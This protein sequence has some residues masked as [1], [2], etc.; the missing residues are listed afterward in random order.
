MKR[1]SRLLAMTSAGALLALAAAPGTA[2]AVVAAGGWA[3]RGNGPGH[4]SRISSPDGLSPSTVAGLRRQ[5]S[6]PTTVWDGVAVSA[7][8]VYGTD[9]DGHLVA[10]SAADGQMLWTA[11]TCGGYRQND[12]FGGQTA[13]AVSPATDAVWVSTG[14]FLTGVRLSTHH[15]F[16]CVSVGSPSLP[17]NTSPTLAGNTVYVN[18]AHAVLALDAATGAQR[19]RQALPSPWLILDAPVADAG[20]ISVPAADGQFGFHGAIFALSAATGA[21]AWKVRTPTYPSG[22]AATGGRVYAGGAPGAWDEQTG[23][24]VWTRFGYDLDSG[25]SVSGGRVYLFGGEADTGPG[26]TNPDG[27]LIALDAAT[28][29]KLWE[30]SIASEGQGV[31]TVGNGVVYVT[32]PIDNGTVT[33]LSSATGAV[34]RQLTHPAGSGFY[35]TQPVVVDGVVY[36]G[37][38][39]QDSGNPFFD[40]WALPAA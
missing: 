3:Q 5:Y 17:G 34:L 29:A 16:A 23:A 7:D 15:Q 2:G 13:P 22:L 38:Y 28:G 36:L 32:D 18:T 8:V 12:G 11:P 31:A 24:A 4:T 14:P 9:L 19:W 39:S 35:D 27:D 33:L 40:A 1:L 25:V 6:V 20:V 37:G 26:G 21:I 30:T 10:T